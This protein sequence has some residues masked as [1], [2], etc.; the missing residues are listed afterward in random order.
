MAQAETEL[1][2]A[3]RH[4]AEGRRT[5]ERQRSILAELRTDG[6]PTSI[7][8]TLLQEFMRSQKL[9]KEHLSRLQTG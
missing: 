5:V 1:E 4:V 6:H 2:M 7:A 9:H 3:R 8:E